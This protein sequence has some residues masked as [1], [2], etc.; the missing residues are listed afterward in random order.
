M[1]PSSIMSFGTKV[2]EQV[3]NPADVNNLQ[4]E[5]VALETKVG[6]DGSAD[7]NSLDYIVKN[8]NSDGGGHVQGATKGGTGQTSYVKGDILA[9]ANSSTLS[10]LGVGG[11][12]SGL[13]ADSTSPMGVKW[14][15]SGQKIVSS[16]IATS[17]VWTKP[18]G[19][20][21]DSLVL[22]E[23]WGGG[24]SGGSATANT[25]AGGGGGGAY[26]YSF[27][28]ASVLQSSVLISTG[29][30]G[31]S[32]RGNARGITGG[33]SVFDV[34]TSMLV[35]YGGGGGG[36]YVTNAGGGGG[37]SHKGAGSLGDNSSS[38]GGEVGGGASIAGIFGGTGGSSF[39]SVLSAYGSCGGGGGGGG[40]SNPTTMGITQNGGGGGGGI[41]SSVF[42]G[43]F[44][45]LSLAGG[46]GSAGSVLG[47]SLT[48]VLSGSI[49]GGGGGA[50]HGAGSSGEG[51]RGMIKIT[52][53]I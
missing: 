47:A 49:P 34:Q 22:I 48:S 41:G 16:T 30:G 24:G 50:S 28:R 13:V 2:V 15:S 10:R 23:M 51:G 52:T 25:E 32:V 5:V 37:G 18:T 3:I 53:F 9:A 35:A 38:S 17:S 21:N 1:Y 42:A 6:V 36:Q 39:N 20:N 7:T 26:V 31:T 4:T 46:N 45:G 8:A 12:G 40:S 14:S 44:G 43:N 19:A 27:V 29:L 33:D 11:D